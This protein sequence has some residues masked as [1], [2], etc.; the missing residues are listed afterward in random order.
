[1]FAF[2]VILILCSPLIL[3]P[4]VIPRLKAA[5]TEKALERL[6]G[7]DGDGLPEGLVVEPVA[8]GPW[9]ARWCDV[10]VDA[11]LTKVECG[12][13]LHDVVETRSGSD[14]VKLATVCFLCSR[15]EKSSAASTVLGPNF[16]RATC[17]SLLEFAVQTAKA[18]E[19]SHRVAA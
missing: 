15:F 11:N 19:R 14:P 10:Q 4:L 6:C 5:K 3:G 17:L 12:G 16:E 18:R 1:M 7:E 2:V 9:N 13:R 8:V